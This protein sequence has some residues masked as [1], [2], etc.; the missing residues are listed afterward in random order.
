VSRDEVAQKIHWTK[1]IWLVSI[2]NPLM[3]LPQLIQLWATQ[4]TAGLSLLF[5]IILLFVQSGF[6]LHV[7]FTRDRFIMISNGIAATMTVLTIASAV[8]L[9]TVQ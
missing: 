3:T 8:Y 9:K 5:L 7:F 4:E 1:I 6:S 2:I